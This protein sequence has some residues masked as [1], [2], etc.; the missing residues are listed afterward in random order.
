MKCNAPTKY[1][2]ILVPRVRGDDESLRGDDG[3]LQLPRICERKR[4]HPPRVLI[5]NQRARDRRLSALAAVFAFAEPAVDADRRAF[6][7]LQ[8]NAG[9]VDQPRSVPDF[10]AQPDGEA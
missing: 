3:E 1:S 9:G 7:F 6:G 5:Q 8:I 4:T 10:A 2:G